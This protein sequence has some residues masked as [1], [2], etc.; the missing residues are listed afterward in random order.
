MFNIK[1]NTFIFILLF[2]IIVATLYPPF[3]WGEEKLRTSNERYD[4]QDSSPKAY[5]ALPLKKYDFLFS[6]S[7]R[8]FQFDWGWNQYKKESYP[9]ILS[10]Q[11]RLDFSELALE[12]VLCVLFAII[13]N[14]S[15]SRFRHIIL[16]G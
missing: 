6:S 7:K 15:F 1:S 14:Y 16:K 13:I 2:L 12:Y 10:L 4:L 8:Q 5:D 11:R 3:I 9:I